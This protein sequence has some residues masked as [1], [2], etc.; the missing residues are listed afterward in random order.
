MIEMAG[1]AVLCAGWMMPLPDVVKAVAHYRVNVIAGDGSQ[2]LQFTNF[3]ASLTPDER[4]E[5]NITKFIY[6]SEPLNLE[7]RE[8]V[9]STLGTRIFSVNGSCEAGPWSV[10]NFD[11]TGEPEDDGVDFIFDTRMMKIEI[12]PASKIGEQEGAHP[13]PD[14]EKGMIVQTSLSRLRNPLVRYVTG[15]L[16]SLRAFPETDKVSSLDAQ[17]LRVIRLYGRDRRFSFKWF[18]EYFE[19]Q[20][21]KT[22]MQTDGWG[23]LQWQVVLEPS[24]SQESRLEVRIYRSELGLV[25]EKNITD[26]LTK[27]F[28]VFHFNE[29][30]FRITFVSGLDGLERSKT[31]TKVIKFV[32]RTA[33]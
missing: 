4:S 3:V 14:G 13:L 30:L 19:F 9:H 8:L 11:I 24:E 17:H 7:Q 1:G 33:H 20:T 26:R 15:D 23:V 32:D 28:K 6:S 27:F 31:G 21:L 18:A 16:G 12:L 2:L 29:Y 22:I 5:I 10:A 25:T